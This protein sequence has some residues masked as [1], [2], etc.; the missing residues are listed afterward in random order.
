MLLRKMWRDLL[1]NKVQFLSIFLMSLMGMLVFVGL[2]A[3]CSGMEKYEG[4]YYEA[5]NLADIWA[6]GIY[7]KKDDVNKAESIPAVIKAERRLK[8]KGKAVLSEEADMIM[9]F[10]EEDVISR[11]SLIDGQPYESGLG[12][13]WL[14]YIFMEKQGLNIGDNI[15]LKL[16]GRSFNVQIR[17][18]VQNPEFVYFLPDASVVMP[19]Y[20]KYGA[21]FMDVKE[22]PDQENLNYNQLILDVDGVDNTGGLSDKEK[23]ICRRVGNELKSTLGSDLLIATDKDAELSY[24]TFRAEIEQHASMVYLFP[25]VFLLIAILGIITTMTRM[26][27]K[28]RVQIGTLKALGFSKK[29]I[30][31]HYASYGF[32]LSLLGGIAGSIAGFYTIGKLIIGMEAESYLI[33]GM[34]TVFTP[35]GFGAIVVSVLVSTIVSYLACRKELKP[36]AAETLKPS[37]PKNLKHTFIERSRLWLKLDFSTQWNFR[38]IMRNKARTMMGMFGVLGCSMLIFAAFCCKDTVDEI[39]GWTYGE[40]NTAKVQILMKE[41]TPLGVTEE[42]AKKYGG[43]MVENAGAEFEVNGVK[44]TGT[45]TVYDSGNYLHYEDEKLRPIK[46]QKNGIA[47]TYKM[48][49]L[50][51]VKQGDMVRWHIA[52]DDRWQNTRI[53]QIYRHPT[54]QGLAMTRQK[55]ESLE[56]YFMPDTVLTNYNIGDKLDD[57]DY[58]T[59][60]NT[61]SEMM[62]ALDSM[63]EMM[64]T[65]IAILII[66]AIILGVVVLYNLGVLSL[67]EK[68]R[69]MATLKVLGFTTGKIRGILQHQNIWVTTVGIIFGIP[70][71]FALIK[72]LFDTMPE[73]MDY[74]ASYRPVSL[75]YTIIGTFALS[76]IVTSMLSRKVKTVDMVDALKGQE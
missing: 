42:Y 6:Q 21:A 50:L 48:A 3:E 18:S 60:V 63:K 26:T 34:D 13:V 1:Q 57:D 51:G 69:E 47:M 72:M 8:T 29:I 44:K 55:Y 19:E 4:H 17:G 56:Y 40:L 33:P 20:G 52:G 64:N 38:D 28:Q 75:L 58:V 15:E 53:S 31:I 71:G 68:S 46:L 45:V 5:N 16:D 22:Y 14:D 39:T 67:A 41:G 32:I 35:K 9:T 59:G 65:M 37:A 49:N 74:V 2:D 43:Q 27:A 76:M 62:A 11:M 24:Q 54:S 66:A 73:S 25:L 10:L 7:F 23:E 30:T 12:G 70:A 61:L 36:P